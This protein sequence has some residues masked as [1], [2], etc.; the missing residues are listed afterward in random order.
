[1]LLGVVFL[2]FHHPLVRW[3]KRLNKLIFASNFWQKKRRFDKVRTHLDMFVWRR[4][5]HELGWIESNLNSEHLAFVFK[6]EMQGFFDTC[7]IVVWNSSCL[8]RICATNFWRY[9]KL[10]VP[11]FVMLLGFWGSR[12]TDESSQ[13]W[14]TWTTLFSPNVGREPKKMVCELPMD[15]A[16]WKQHLNLG[17]ERESPSTSFTRSTCLRPNCQN[18]LVS[19][20]AWDITKTQWF[21]YNFLPKWPLFWLEVRPCFG[22]LTFKN[23]VVIGA[24][25][26]SWQVAGKSSAVKHADWNG[27]CLEKAIE[28]CPSLND[29]YS[30]LACCGT[31]QL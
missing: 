31:N 4:I 19:G 13:L 12:S 18:G 2:R 22:G 17:M 29:E 21:I 23:R 26:N 14:R 1:M 20:V 3:V 30:C 24:G 5:L 10:K 16:I 6:I 7:Q 25:C 9:C 8:A 28:G 27:D 11:C 15:G